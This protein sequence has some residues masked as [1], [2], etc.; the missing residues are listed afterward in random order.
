[1][2]NR[3]QRIRIDPLVRLEDEN[4]TLRTR[5]ASRETAY[6]VKE[7]E[8]ITAEHTSDLALAQVI[9]HSPPPTLP[10]SARCMR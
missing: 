10:A 4:S 5:I 3:R 9:D 7:A 6:A 8:L 2:N 1:M